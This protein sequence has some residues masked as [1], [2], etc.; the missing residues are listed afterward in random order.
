MG[1]PQSFEVVVVGGGAA[2]IAAATAAA[3]LGA[4]TL[5]VERSEV[6][7]GNA[8]GAFVHTICGLYRPASEGDA[9]HAHRGLPRRF[10]A[11]LRAAG[12]AGEPERAGR[13]W[14][15]PTDPPRL[16][17]FAAK[18]CAGTAGLAVR[19][20]CELVGAELACGAARAPHTLLLRGP[21]EAEARVT[22][23]LVLD[24]SGDGAAAA[25]GGADVVAAAPGELQIPS[26]IFRLEG[27]ED[28]ELHGFAKL[29]V[30]HALA[31]AVR[32]GALP[33]GCESVLVRPGGGAGEA[34]LT[35]NLPRPEDAPYSPLDD[36]Q[37]AALE[38]R[39]RDWARL[40]AEHLR[41]TR[42]AFARS[43]VAA[44]PGRLGVRET[45]RLVGV[46]TLHRADVLE[47]RTR[48]DEVAV[49]TWPIELWHDPRRA[50]FEHP[51]APCSVPLGA[52]V[53]RS[54]PRL[55]MAG[56]CLSA[57]HRAL[58]A[59][60]VLGTALA[61]GEALGVAGALAADAGTTLQEVAP[62]EVRHQIRVLGEGEARP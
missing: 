41:R 36:A 59:L 39:A 26:F 53:S 50:H 57:S 30:T 42:P 7:G 12:A 38:G 6:L 54:H 33:G 58:G 18:L 11:G 2:G 31:G 40:I 13:V 45:R 51:K 10:A 60:R 23:H 16:G 3:G 46:E 62:A 20:R 44:W 56:R 5:L 1:A 8:T 9:L 24:T 25:L 32:S 21:G 29:R 49:S 27:V 4:R 61:T 28:A 34:Y 35:L 15:L 48:T 55:G 47:G 22:T 43:R 14:V 17:A 19:T 52:L 37:R